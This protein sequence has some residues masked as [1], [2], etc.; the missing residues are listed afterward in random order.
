MYCV[1][2]ASLLLR[3][4]VLTV[5]DNS[6][7]SSISQAIQLMGICREYILGLQ[8]ELARKELPRRTV[9]DQVFLRGM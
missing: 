7:I 1:H 8:M 5:D 9:Q 4:W 2:T 3:V 6:M